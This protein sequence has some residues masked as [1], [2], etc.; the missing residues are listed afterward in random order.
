[1]SHALATDSPP[2]ELVGNFRKV[3]FIVCCISNLAAWNLLYSQLEPEVTEVPLKKVNAWSERIVNAKWRNMSQMFPAKS[4][5]TGA[6]FGWTINVYFLPSKEANQIS[7]PGRF[8]TT[9]AR[10]APCG[11]WVDARLDSHQRH[12]MN[13]CVE[14]W[15]KLMR[16]IKLSPLS[17]LKCMMIIPVGLDFCNFGQPQMTP[18]KLSTLFLSGF[19]FQHKDSHGVVKP[20]HTHL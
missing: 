14:R 5:R 10:Q 6:W 12:S 9:P 19:L 16:P 8:N 11:M 4:G 17:P 3:Q 20:H 18:R 15:F 13:F 2:F 7:L 1:M